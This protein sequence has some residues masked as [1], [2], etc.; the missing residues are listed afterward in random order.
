M[1]HELES[2]INKNNYYYKK[3]IIMIAILITGI[4]LYC[5]CQANYQKNIVIG[6]Q[7]AVFLNDTEK[8]YICYFNDSKIF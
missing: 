7:N 4:L 1:K 3:I 8:E 2:N 5:G 6:E